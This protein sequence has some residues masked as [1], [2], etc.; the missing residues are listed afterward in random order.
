MLKRRPGGGGVVQ[1]GSERLTPTRHAGRIQA[2]QR[3]RKVT[4]DGALRFQ[5]SFHL[6]PARLITQT[7]ERVRREFVGYRHEA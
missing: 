7:W 6:E 3:A 1:L 2:T 4:D 5:A